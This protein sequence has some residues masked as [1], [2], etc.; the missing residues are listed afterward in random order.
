MWCVC[1]VSICALKCVSA[2]AERRVAPWRVFRLP[3]TFFVPGVSCTP[4][5][6]RDP[7]RTSACYSS[8]P[9]TGIQG[10]I[11]SASIECRGVPVLGSP[12]HSGGGSPPLT[13]PPPP[14]HPRPSSGGGSSSWPASAG[15]WKHASSRSSRRAPRP[16]KVCPGWLPC[17][18]TTLPTVQCFVCDAHA[19]L[20]S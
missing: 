12:W 4:C 15:C 10:I 2:L 18:T 13:P 9:G 7:V 16:P 14:P 8:P 1:A 11:A 19:P 3:S 17:W 5:P 20:W 6:F